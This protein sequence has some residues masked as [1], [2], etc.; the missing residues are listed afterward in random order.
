M[1]HRLMPENQEPLEIRHP[2]PVRG[3]FRA[4]SSR[5]ASLQF[6]LVMKLL[7]VFTLLVFVAAG[8]RCGAEEP[9]STDEAPAKSSDGQSGKNRLT[10]AQEAKQRLDMVHFTRCEGGA[11]YPE[12]RFT[13]WA[14]AELRAEYNAIPTEEG[15]FAW[16]ADRFRKQLEKGDILSGHDLGILHLYGLG[17]EMDW[18][19]AQSYFVEP[20]KHGL[21]MGQRYLA[22][23]LVLSPDQPQNARLAGELLIPLLTPSYLR[24]RWAAFKASHILAKSASPQ[25]RA[26]AN[27]LIE[28][29]VEMFQARLHSPPS[30]LDD[31]K[32]FFEQ[33]NALTKALLGDPTEVNCQ[34][35]DSIIEAWLVAEPDSVQAKVRSLG[36]AV[37]RKDAQREWAEANAL[38]KTNGIDESTEQWAERVRV[39][40]GLQ[41]SKLG[42]ELSWED[43]FKVGR[44]G[45]Y[46]DALRRY[47]GPMMVVVWGLI[48][49]L[50]AGV[51]LLTRFRRKNE[52]GFFL[53]SFWSTVFLFAE[54][55]IVGPTWAI[56]LYCPI[57][58]YLLWLA[59]T[60][61]KTLPYF[62]A[63]LR[64]WNS[65][66][67]TWL[68]ILALCVLLF[69]GIL[70]VIKG[71]ALLYERV[72]GVELAAQPVKLL[73]NASLLSRKL[74]IV[75]AAGIF[76][77]A[78]EEIIFRGFLHDWLSRKLPLAWAMILGS[79]LF[80]FAHGIDYG[81]PLT[82]FG[83]ALLWLRLRYQSLFPSILLHGMNNTVVI[84]LMYSKT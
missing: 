65:T 60:G 48:L 16:L 15:K 7:L 69:F 64:K 70:T 67:T 54:V 28:L 53:L 79:L 46:R 75:L 57:A 10:L 19:K 44:L 20:V 3:E 12:P 32:L 35:A 74:A 56:A 24:G 25:D 4:A 5:A 72:K 40:S 49:L 8:L 37:S 55:I 41:L 71:Y 63:P 73:L 29:S 62:V 2:A 13:V 51:S 81:L 84:L 18:K 31:R 23:L 9:K 80:G 68:E 30:D 17:V 39:L 52:V 50:L 6:S 11:S 36:V 14:P 34:R 45:K 77:P 33:V 42:N 78:L 43:L 83:L 61:P 82:C 27:R 47:G 76:V 58:L 66:G 21:R 59:A 38:L 26:L 22:E 1:S